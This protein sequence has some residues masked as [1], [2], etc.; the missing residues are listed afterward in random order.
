ME[1]M[2]TKFAHACRLLCGV[3]VGAAL[4]FASAHPITAQQKDK[5]NKNKKDTPADTSVPAMMSDEQQIDVLIST[6]LGAWQIGDLDRLRQA[7][8]DNVVL[9]SGNWAPPIIG[10]TNFAAMYQQQRTHMQQVRMDR[11]NTYIKLDGNFGWACYQWDFSATVD[12]QPS[13]A[14]GQ[15]TLIVEKQNG[16]WVIAHNHTSLVQ[17]SGA[18]TPVKPATSA[19]QPPQ[20]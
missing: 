18:L 20:R 15:T 16:K 9:V 11:S 10:W 3:L 1:K 7:Y 5:K 17:G 8:A 12:G 13:A 4:L 19:A 14:Q 6:M 2:R